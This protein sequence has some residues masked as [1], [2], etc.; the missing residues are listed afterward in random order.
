MPKPTCPLKLPIPL[1]EVLCG[2][3]GGVWVAGDKWGW[4]PED[5][6]YTVHAFANVIHNL[7]INWRM[8]KVFQEDKA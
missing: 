6:L 2:K 8:G 7:E 5:V 4:K 3:G 1:A